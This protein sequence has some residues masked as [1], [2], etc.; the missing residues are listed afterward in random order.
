MARW[1]RLELAT[2]GLENR[3]SVQLSYHRKNGRPWKP[4]TICEPRHLTT[5]SAPL[6][7]LLRHSDAAGFLRSESTGAEDRMNRIYGI[8]LDAV[9]EPH[10]ELLLWSTNQ[11]NLRG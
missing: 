6:A 3:C 8:C 2:D 5:H 7:I 11:G 10:G 4:P 1:A 9:F